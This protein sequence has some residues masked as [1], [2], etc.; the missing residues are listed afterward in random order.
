M[1]LRSVVSGAVGDS[2]LLV[3]R[4]TV[5]WM[6]AHHEELRRSLE[7][8]GVGDDLVRLH[9]GALRS[10]QRR[11]GRRKG[12]DV[13]PARHPGLHDLRKPRLR[14]RPDP[15]LRPSP[16]RRLRPS[17]ARVSSTATTLCFLA[18]LAPSRTLLSCTR[19][20]SAGSRTLLWL[21]FK[22]APLQATLPF[23]RSVAVAGVLRRWLGSARPGLRLSGGFGR[24]S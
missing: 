19:R 13:P 23:G 1:A 2:D 9:P 17:L 18:A 14:E 8:P 7:T 12:R 20:S 15:D 22:R 10:G 24:S 5:G 16:D 21:R 3:L 11:D 4:S 6:A